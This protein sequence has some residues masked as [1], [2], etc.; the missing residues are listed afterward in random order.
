MW[1]VGIN[2]TARLFAFLRTSQTTHH[3][4]PA[5]A[6]RRKRERARLRGAGDSHIGHQ[7]ARRLCDL[8]VDRDI[9]MA[10]VESRVAVAITDDLQKHR[11]GRRVPGEQ[12]HAAK[13]I[14]RREL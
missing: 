13:E 10:A 11:V 8:D 2:P 6:Q 14:E 3:T 12:F 1:A 5:Y 9:E 4:Q 7:A